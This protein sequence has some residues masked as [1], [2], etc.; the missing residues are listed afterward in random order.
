MM[1]WGIKIIIGLGTFMLFIISAGL[2]MVVKNTD[3][4]EE[5][6]YYEK[7]LTYDQVYAEKQNLLKDHAEPTVQVLADTLCL[8]FKEAHNHGVLK[9]KRPADSSMDVTWPFATTDGSY[10]IAIESFEKGNW[11]LEISWKNGHTSYLSDHSL[12]F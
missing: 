3:S 4:L 8:Q 10:K 7:S 9:F 11:Q 5:S 2:Y 12:Y 6:D 1:S